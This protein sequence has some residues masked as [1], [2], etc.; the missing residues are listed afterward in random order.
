MILGSAAERPAL[1]ERDRELGRL[2]AL[3]AAARDGRGGAM[4][5]QVTRGLASPGC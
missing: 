4:L 1:L 5:V 2:D 3:V